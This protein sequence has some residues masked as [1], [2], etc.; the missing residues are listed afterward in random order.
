M[1]MFVLMHSHLKLL[2]PVAAAAAAADD[3]DDTDAE[4]YR[5]ASTDA[6]RSTACIPSDTDVVT[7]SSAR[8]HHHHHFGRPGTLPISPSLHRSSSKHSQI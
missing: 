5:K 8:D 7:I 3:D 1:R 2:G 6:D 4:E